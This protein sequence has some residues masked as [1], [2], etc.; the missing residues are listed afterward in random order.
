MQKELIGNT[1]FRILHGEQ[2][3]E[4]FNQL[5]NAKLSK[6]ENVDGEF[7]KSFYI[8]IRTDEKR[9]LGIRIDNTLTLSPYDF[10]GNRKNNKDY[11]LEDDSIL[12]TIELLF[13]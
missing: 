7:T 5:L 3:K 10:N 6:E 11:L 2:A 1:A 9:A 8:L 13:E 4:L 12:K